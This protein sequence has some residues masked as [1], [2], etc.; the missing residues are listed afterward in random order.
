M[1][2]VLKVSVAAGQ[3]RPGMRDRVAN[4]ATV[5]SWA[6]AVTYEFV[7][8]VARREFWRKYR[9]LTVAVPDD[10][11]DFDFAELAKKTTIQKIYTRVCITDGDVDI[12]DRGS[13]MAKVPKVPE[14]HFQEFFLK[15][16]WGGVVVQCPS[17][18]AGAAAKRISTN[19]GN[20]IIKYFSTLL[21]RILS[22]EL[23]VKQRAEEELRTRP[24]AQAGAAPSADHEAA[25]A[26]AA[27][28][29][30]GATAA[31]VAAAIERGDGEVP[32]D[33]AAAAAQAGSDVD[34]IV[35]KDIIEPA[36]ALFAVVRRG[37]R[38][39][40]ADELKEDDDIKKLGDYEKDIYAKIQPILLS[41]RPDRVFAGKS[42]Y[43]DILDSPE[44]H[45]EGYLFCW[46]LA[47]QM[48]GIKVP[49]ILPQARQGTIHATVDRSVIHGSILSAG[50]RRVVGHAEGAAEA[51]A[52]AA[53][54][55]ARVTEMGT[56]GAAGDSYT[57]AVRDATQAAADAA[58]AS[59][60]A[61]RAAPKAVVDTTP[62]VRAQSA[63]VVA[64][65][66]ARFAA[67]EQQ[68]AQQQQAEVIER[69]PAANTTMRSWGPVPWRGRASAVATS[70]VSRLQAAPQDAAVATRAAGKRVAA[71]QAA[72]AQARDAVI[73]ATAAQRSLAEAAKAATESGLTGQQQA[74]PGV[75]QSAWRRALQAARAAREAE[76]AAAAAREAATKA[77]KAEER[78]A[79]LLPTG[80]NPPQQPTK[81]QLKVAKL[82]TPDRRLVSMMFNPRCYGRLD[83]P[84]SGFSFH[85]TIATNGVSA[86]LVL[87][88]AKERCQYVEKGDKPKVDEKGRLR[89]VSADDDED[90]DDVDMGE[91]AVGPAAE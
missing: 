12:G 3:W 66:N 29:A 33:I 87:S 80:V 2:S 60:A 79:D 5:D 57:A 21:Y 50:E 86:S 82:T 17:A 64:S 45:L 34:P 76:A 48:G 23:N 83:R 11:H 73:A 81:A 38:D 91:G 70:L 14:V 61:D 9:P 58:A 54:A 72:Q 88:T 77:G 56:M 44:A 27:A 28:M 52:R 43:I 40:G 74:P 62:V 46:H 67:R 25:A 55:A 30:G 78:A 59:A 90:D 63:Q 35:K 15:T 13:S 53:R 7:Y 31:Q 36:S 75:E 32:S 47:Q 24:G 19:I 85:S 39:I 8:D 51:A 71:T 18:V 6:T 4:V 68:D 26:A 49:A 20:H 41:Y 10:W 16:G 37:I 1:P 42:L 65:N 84:N 89:G 22:K 69:S